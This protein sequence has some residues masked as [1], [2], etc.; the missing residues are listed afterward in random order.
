MDR[1]LRKDHMVVQTKLSHYGRRGSPSGK[2]ELLVA[3]GSRLTARHGVPGGPDCSS[4]RFPR[5]LLLAPSSL[6]DDFALL[7]CAGLLG[8]AMRWRSRS[9]SRSLDA[10]GRVALFLLTSSSICYVFELRWGLRMQSR[11]HRV[12]LLVGVILVIM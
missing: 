1:H 12:M 3:R 10:F 9:G 11:M 8:F 6:G 7:D 2:A 5:T 4:A